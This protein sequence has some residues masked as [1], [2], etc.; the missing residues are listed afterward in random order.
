[1]ETGRVFRILKER[2]HAGQVWRTDAVDTQGFTLIELMLA[3]SIVGILASLAIPNYIDFLEKA[4]V[5]RAIAE[6][7]ALTKELKGFAIGG[8]GIP[9]YAGAN[10][11]QHHAG[12][13]GNSVSVLP[14]Q[15]FGRR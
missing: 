8:G 9:G 5:A 10:W 15:L 2:Q 13:M 3:V 6:L 7:H 4:R 14:D 12:P 11:T 1:M